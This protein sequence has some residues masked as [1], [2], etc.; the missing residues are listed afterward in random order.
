VRNVG[1]GEDRPLIADRYEFWVYQ[2]MRNALEAGDLFCQDSVRFR[3]F[4]D[5]LIDDRQ[6]QHK[7]R[8]IE[9]AGLVALKQPVEEHLAF[10][11]HLLEARL[12]EVNRRIA[13]GEN[14]HLQF[15]Q[16]G[17]RRQWSLNY[18]A[19]VEAANHPVF[20]G[21]APANIA[22]VLDYVSQHC[23]FLDAFEHVLGR[24]TRQPL[25]E[26][27][28][29]AA[30]L[31]WG[32]NLG[33]G[34]M[35][36]ISDID[37][38]RLASTSDNRI[39]LETLRE[40]NDRISNGIAKLPVFPHYSL[41]TVVHS[42][43]DGQKFETRRDTLNSRH[44]PKYFGLKKGI[45]SYTLVANHVPVN[46]EIIGANEHESHYVFDLLHNNATDI[47]IGTHSTDTHGVNQVNFAILQLFGY[48]FAPRYRDIYAVATESLYGF[49]H[50]SHYTE[51]VIK[52]IRK[53]NVDLIISEWDNIQRIMVSLAQKTT[54][55]NIITA[56]LSAYAR[57]NRTKRALW[58]YDNIIKSLSCW[59]T[60]IR[61][62]CGKTCRKPLTAAKATTS[63]AGPSPMPTSA[64]CGSK[65][66]RNSKYGTNAAACLPTALCITTPASCHACWHV[67]N[68]PGTERG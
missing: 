4:E 45:V 30:L 60:L 33:L 42:S 54:T 18:P 36:E 14:P 41:G 21:L 51:A 28:L 27:A 46:A 65:P 17:R 49:R 29:V 43:S 56:K 53:I 44:S 6:W 66:S 59:T 61:R 35:G 10:L 3:S 50:P 63:C 39:R 24:F 57:K 9:E 5:D 25:D 12:D 16:Q 40:A 34:R 20:D 1:S 23:P 22:S 13:A 47:E 7:D 31:A 37:Y 52:P 32:T 64:S 8:L 2:L 38:Q 67:E 19:P 62:L 11:E 15:K 68:R 58:E 55:Q 26:R 48:Q